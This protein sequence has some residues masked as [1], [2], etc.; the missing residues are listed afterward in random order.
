MQLDNLSGRQIR[1]YR[2][3][4]KLG[5]GGM[6]T[7]F[8]VEHVLLRT[9][10]AMKVIRPVK[11]QD[12]QYVL[13]FER[14]ARV[15]V[16]LDH[17][18]LVRVY[19][20]FQ[21]EGCLFLIMEYVPGESM[22][23]R[24]RRTQ[25]F[26][27]RDVIE[28][29]SQACDGLHV[30]HQAGIVH[31]DLAPDNLLI[32]P[33]SDGYERIKVIDFGIAKD[34]TESQT[35]GLT[36]MGKFVGKL[37]YCSP[38]QAAGN[39][40]DQ[41]SDIYSLGLVAHRALTGRIP[42]HPKSPFEA[43]ALRQ[44]QDAPTL[45]E[46]RPDGCYPGRLEA[47]VARALRRDPRERFQSVMEFREA[48]HDV[49]GEC[50]GADEDTQFRTA[51]NAAK[52]RSEPESVNVRTEHGTAD[53][54][55]IERPKAGA[56]IE[57]DLDHLETTARDFPWGIFIVIALAVT[58][59]V[60]GW[61]Q[62]NHFGK[63]VGT[64]PTPPL[65]TAAS[66]TPVMMTPEDT[67]TPSPTMTETPTMTPEPL[68]ETLPLNT[69][70]P[71]ETR[72]EPTSADTE[73]A[74]AQMTATVEAE[75]ARWASAPTDVPMTRITHGAVVIG[76]DP[77]ESGR[78]DDESV[79]AVG[80]SRDYQISVTEVTQAQYLAVMDHNPSR[81]KGPD[82]PVESVT[83]F[84]ALRFC[85]A[86]SIRQGIRPAYEIT[87]E[88][89][90]IEVSW[91]PNSGGYRLPT[92]AEWETAARAGRKT[93]FT[94]GGRLTQGHANFDNPSGIK[95]VRYYEPNAAGLYDVEGNVREWCWD[96]YGEYGTEPVTDPAGHPSS[97]RRVVRGGSFRT[98]MEGCRLAGRDSEEA[99]KRSDDIG[100]RVVRN[101]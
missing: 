51:S 91:L 62:I 75:R 10:R 81:N 48:L 16:S 47:V 22:E 3:I 4:E 69:P 96:G 34:V 26:S 11:N 86:L 99:G 100:F 27:A 78:R 28:I 77:G 93:P 24:L 92:E 40:L 30:A 31:R 85:N 89:D 45:S 90:S 94:V 36:V 1:E 12:A 13:R 44:V 15:L 66:P 50:G 46:S 68:P 56:P 21:E 8:K 74:G 7:V 14:E 58:A 59:F 39:A 83:W 84:D 97:S 49:M 52:H 55:T 5:Q 71:I 18:N 70:A 37:A 82:Y 6:A 57:V 23:V 79:W 61:Y 20:F 98:K 80:I 87:K 95:T 42:F 60:I 35:N 65:V 38:E 54:R 2:V 67:A 53:D 73:R 64:V 17:I 33:L 72:P 29:L 63:A 43:L 25:V 101:P 76:S 88:G 19:D 32:M 41:R 9:F